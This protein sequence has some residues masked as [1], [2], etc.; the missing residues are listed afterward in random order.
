MKTIADKIKQEWK[1]PVIGLLHWDGKLMDSLD[2]GSKEE[3]LPILVSG[4]GGAKLLGVPALP[5][6]GEEGIGVLIAEATTELLEEWG[7]ADCIVGM[8]FDT[9]SS[10]TG[11]LKLTV[12]NSP[13]SYFVVFNGSDGVGNTIKHV[14]NYLGQL[15]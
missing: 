5:P 8:V 7:C 13:T 12:I 10:N 11:K 15:I 3:R 14:I 2:G 9:T 6:V 1:H 4:V